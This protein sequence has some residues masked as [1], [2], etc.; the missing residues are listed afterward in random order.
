M[1]ARTDA[2]RTLQAK[3]D[4]QP[5]STGRL[6]CPEFHAVSLFALLAQ[7]ESDRISARLRSRKRRLAAAGRHQRNQSSLGLRRVYLDADGREV[8]RFEGRMQFVASPHYAVL[9]RAFELYTGGLEVNQESD[10]LTAEF[11]PNTHWRPAALSHV[12]RN[13]AYIG[14]L[15]GMLPDGF[16]EVPNAWPAMIDRETWDDALATLIWRQ[17]SRPPSSRGSVRALRPRV[18]CLRTPDAYQ[19]LPAQAEEH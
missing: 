3:C 16:G 14:T 12:L 13:P 9:R 6:P 8:P 15:R 10:R 19:L 1:R 17:A 5:R 18:M 11:G 2:Y 7:D 4:D